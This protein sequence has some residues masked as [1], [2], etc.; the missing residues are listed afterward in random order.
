MYRRIDCV[1]AIIAR[2]VAPRIETIGKIALAGIG[3]SVAGPLGA[4][5]CSVL[6]PEAL[7][8]LRQYLEGPAETLAGVNANYLHEKL[9]EFASRT[10]SSDPL[11]NALREA[12]RRSLAGIHVPEFNDWFANW[13]ERLK[14]DSALAS[15]PVGDAF[16][17][18]ASDDRFEVDGVAVLERL[19]LERRASQPRDGGLGLNVPRRPMPDALRVRI[20]EKLPTALRAELNSTLTR[21]EHREAWISAQQ[22]FQS[23]VLVVLT[24]IRDVQTSHTRTLDSHTQS[25][26][27]I[28]AMLLQQSPE[29]VRRLEEQLAQERLERAEAQAREKD[30]LEK[31]AALQRDLE[32]RPE[33]GRG[34]ASELIGAGDFERAG[35]LLDELR[36]S[37]VQEAA[38]LAFERGRLHE[39]QFQPEDA[40]RCYT[41]AW[42]L[43]PENTAYDIAYARLS[44]LQNHYAD[45]REAYERLLPRYRSLAERNPDAYLPDVATSLNNLGIL[46][47]ATQRLREAEE[48]YRE[49]LQLRRSLAERNPDAYL[50]NVAK[51]L[52]NQA[53]LFRALGQRDQ[54]REAASEAVRIFEDF[55]ERSPDT[56]QP[57][58]AQ[59]QQIRHSIDS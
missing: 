35:A 46:Y 54:A 13:D 24:G 4:F 55:V 39:L 21:E 11:Q 7:G 45:A 44:Q 26:E 32:A 17:F 34:R 22:A 1:R 59:A 25:L 18:T 48:A 16:R 8:L 27:E 20:L 31:L 41:D 57:M 5:C 2:A 43:D 58:L 38:S 33:G 56:F 6:S 42:R 9:R 37:A 36:Q 15:M 51:T 47:R 29:A 3:A 19:D 14:D 49:S 52:A 40:L 30:L 50:P 28:K 53:L 12:L 23:E 10:P